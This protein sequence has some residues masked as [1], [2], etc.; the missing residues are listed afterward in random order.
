MPPRRW[1]CSSLFAVY[2]S[3]CSGSNRGPR[4]ILVFDVAEVKEGLFWGD[5]APRNLSSAHR[6]APFGSRARSL[7]ASGASRRSCGVSHPFQG[8][9]AAHVV[10]EVLHPDLHPCSGNLGAHAHRL[11]RARRRERAFERMRFSPTAPVRS[12]VCHSGF[13]AASSIVSVSS[14]AAGR[15]RVSRGAS[16]CR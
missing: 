15:R 7:G 16:C 6:G 8:D 13:L 3:S 10:G 1:N 5:A 11:T 9:E 2:P 14:W 4:K 12:T